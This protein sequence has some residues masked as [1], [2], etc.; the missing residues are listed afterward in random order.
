V[1]V[2]V[3]TQEAGK[4]KREIKEKEREK[5]LETG[6]VSEP[7]QEAALAK[8]QR[9]KR[10]SQNQKEAMKRAATASKG[11]N[12][13]KNS[14]PKRARKASAHDADLPPVQSPKVL[15]VL[16]GRRKTPTPNDNHGCKHHGLSELSPCDKQWIKA[17]VKVGAWLHQ[18]PCFDCASDQITNTSR[19]RVLDASVLLQAKGKNVAFICNCGPQG[20]K[21]EEG[22]DGKEDYQCDMMLCVPCYNKRDSIREGDP[23][24]KRRSTRRPPCL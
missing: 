17:Y 10:V 6:G 13:G 24:S 4:R 14:I 18:K 7:T 16:Q 19:E 9:K 22:E 15:P 12:K 2:L 1:L 8:T 5:E 11:E 21:M 3:V 20:H 23:S